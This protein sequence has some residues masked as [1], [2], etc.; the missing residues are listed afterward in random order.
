MRVFFLFLFA[1]KTSFPFFLFV[2]TSQPPLAFND[3]S[4]MLIVWIPF[5]MKQ[6]WAFFL[7]KS[8]KSFLS[9]ENTWT[10]TPL[11]KVLEV[12]KYFHLEIVD[13]VE[14]LMCKTERKFSPVLMGWTL[15]NY[16]LNTQSNLNVNM[17]FILN[18]WPAVLRML[19]VRAER[20]KCSFIKSWDIFL[21]CGHG[22]WCSVESSS[23][24]HSKNSAK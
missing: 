9:L 11:K 6:M 17:T 15:Y 8:L 3:P 4:Q 2:S 23:S 24:F 20:K 1:L 13:N 12:S 18:C 21:V 10:W 16:L 19:R 7:R 14:V 5:D 22:A